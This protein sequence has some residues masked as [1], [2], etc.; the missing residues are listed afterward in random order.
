MNEELRELVK[1]SKAVG[2]DSSLVLGGFGNTSVK[3]AEGRFMYI[4]QSGTAL[5]DMTSRGGWRRLKLDSVLAILKDRTLAGMAAGEREDKIAVTLLIACDDKFCVAG[6]GGRRVVKPSIESCFHST[7]DRFVIHLHP[8]A[9]LA[10]CCARGGRAELERLFKQERFP[11]V[12]VPYADPGYMLAKRIEKLVC[13]YK[14]RYGR[15]TAIMF[16]QNHG[17]IVAANSS[18]TALR[19]VRRV[20]N[21]C[22]SKL[23][24]PKAVK[25]RPADN[26]AIAEA[27][28]AIRKAIFLTAGKRVTVKH[29]I[30][31]AIAGFMAG[32]D[33]RRLCRGGAVTPDELVYARG[34]AMWVDKAEP[35]I[36]LNKL[37][38]R[39]GLGAETPAGFLIKPLGLFVAGGRGQLSL[40]KDVIVTY[41]GVRSFAADL[42]G[43]CP[44]NKRQRQ[45]ITGRYEKG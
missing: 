34:A 6:R 17:L 13:D 3:T 7:L 15:A 38:R 11:P 35:Q 22:D 42:G 43:I 10:Y 18:D 45:F 41:L 2:S 40:I 36:I 12:W 39:I 21:T 27:C 16:L 4:K 28:S 33:G 8:A 44:L 26:E 23:K 20:V 30:N 9:V 14:A 25:I 1:I 29:F 19:L 32:S 5:K 24:R 37:R 31:E